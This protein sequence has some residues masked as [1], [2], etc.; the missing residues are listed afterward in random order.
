MSSSWPTSRAVPRA[1][2]TAR[3]KLRSL[4]AAIAVAQQQVA[5]A[6]PQATGTVMGER[7]AGDPFSFPRS[8]SF[9]DVS[10]IRV[11]P[12]FL[13]TILKGICL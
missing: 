6:A 3:A 8:L 13:L 11:L 4:A 12:C 1:G 2:L 7:G 10:N 5:S 9:L